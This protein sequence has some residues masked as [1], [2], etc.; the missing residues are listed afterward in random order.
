MGSILKDVV[1]RKN[2]LSKWSRA[3][4]KLQEAEN[5]IAELQ[6]TI[7]MLRDEVPSTLNALYP[8]SSSIN[9]L[10]GSYIS[11]S[12]IFISTTTTVNAGQNSVFL[13]LEKKSQPISLWDLMV[14]WVK[15]NV[16]AAA[17]MGI[18]AQ[19]PSW[20]FSGGR[21]RETE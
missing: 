17:I 18:L 10:I 13:Q 4:E 12:L 9:R 21:T 14:E 5:A 20:S 6:S 16:V 1:N 15:T 19:L 8:N 7:Q 2:L 3:R 11:T